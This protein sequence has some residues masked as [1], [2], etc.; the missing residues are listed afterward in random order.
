MDE[1]HNDWQRMLERRAAQQAQ[2]T[3]AERTER[4]LSDLVVRLAMDWDR[5]RAAEDLALRSGL[6]QQ[7]TSLVAYIQQIR[8]EQGEL[9][10]NELLGY[11]RFAYGLAETMPPDEPP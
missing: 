2:E 4:E 8:A 5:Q 11:L 3:A 7:P 6:S 1:Q 9:V 10:A